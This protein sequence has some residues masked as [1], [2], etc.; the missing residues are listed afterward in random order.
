MTI[1]HPH[2]IVLLLSTKNEGL[3]NVM[4]CSCDNKK[5]EENADT[6]ESLSAGR[7]DTRIDAHGTV[8]ALDQFGLRYI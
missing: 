5:V 8:D 7:P 1:P 3:Q 6:V 2:N 4:L